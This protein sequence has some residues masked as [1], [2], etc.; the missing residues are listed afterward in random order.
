MQT[1]AHHDQ[2]I[3]L[4]GAGLSGLDAVL[5]ALAVLELERVQR[6]DVHRQFFTPVFVEKLLQARATPN[7]SVGTAFGAHLEGALQLGAVQRR[8]A[9]VALD[10]QAFGHV[11]RALRGA[12][13]LGTGN[14]IEPTQ[15]RTSEN[16]RES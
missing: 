1:T 6:A 13:Q 3:A 2:C 9:I 11:A 5:V 12:D 7:R 15:D 16:G 8:V 4:V 10:P 14:F